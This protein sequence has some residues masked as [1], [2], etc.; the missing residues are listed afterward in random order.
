M[1]SVELERS[2]EQFD[3][4]IGD[5][6]DPVEGGPCYKLYTKVRAGLCTA[7]ACP[8]FALSLRLLA[9][10]FLDAVLAPNSRYDF[11]S[12]SASLFCVSSSSFDSPCKC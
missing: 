5:L 7:S 1:R 10:L 12:D 2:T 3:I 6:A 11:P 4:I 9:T 8:L